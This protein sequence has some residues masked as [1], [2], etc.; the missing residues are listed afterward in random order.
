MLNIERHLYRF[1]LPTQLIC[2]ISVIRHQFDFDYMISFKGTLW[3]FFHSI[4]S[5]FSSVSENPALVLLKSKITRLFGMLLP[6]SW[7]LS[8]FSQI[9]RECYKNW[10]SNHFCTIEPICDIPL[11][12]NF[13]INHSSFVMAK[14]LWGKSDED[15]CMLYGI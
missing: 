3:Q 10:C 14:V 2:E 5:R 9:K 15:H 7:K 4:V 1:A 6:Y 13:T 8:S 12:M 11:W